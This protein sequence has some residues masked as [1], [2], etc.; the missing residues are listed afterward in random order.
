MHA[1]RMHTMKWT[2]M[3]CLVVVVVLNSAVVPVFTVRGRSA[4]KLQDVTERK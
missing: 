4:F 1:H 3:I 2:E